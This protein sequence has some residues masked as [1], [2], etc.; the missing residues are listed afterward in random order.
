MVI[1][2][3]T[4]TLRAPRAIIFDTDNT[5]YAYDQPHMKASA[6]APAIGNQG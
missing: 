4:R 5:L 1:Q 3:C 6:V 2:H